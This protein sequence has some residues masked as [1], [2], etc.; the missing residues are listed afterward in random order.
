MK[1][2]NDRP[3]KVW[4]PLARKAYWHLIF[5]HSES[6]GHN[7]GSVK[8]CSLRCICLL[9]TSKVTSEVSW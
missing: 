5:F 3:T 4:G 8:K 6:N 2:E 9:L 1:F 7:S